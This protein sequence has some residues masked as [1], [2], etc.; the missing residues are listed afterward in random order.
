[1]GFERLGNVTQHRQDDLRSRRV[2]HLVIGVDD[3]HGVLTAR[4]VRVG[5][6]AANRARVVAEYDE[7]VMVERYRDIYSRAIGTE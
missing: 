1:M 6:G 4:Q 7:A 3:D 2:V 5:L